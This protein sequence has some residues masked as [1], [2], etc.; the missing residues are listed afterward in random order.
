MRKKELGIF[1]TKEEWERRNRAKAI[2]VS[3]LLI[4]LTMY[5]VQFILD[6]TQK[7]CAQRAEVQRPVQVNC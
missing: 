3:N 5:D 4:G 6:V 1:P 2:E 7:I